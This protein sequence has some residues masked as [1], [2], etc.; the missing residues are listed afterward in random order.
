M[1][2]VISAEVRQLERKIAA[3]LKE[4]DAE[5]AELL[6]VAQALGA[7][8][9]SAVAEAAPTRRRRSSPSRGSSTKRASTK[10]S[11]SSATKRSSRSASRSSSARKSSARPR[12]G[13]REQFLAAVQAQPGVT[14]A[15]VAKKL[16]LDDATSM[17]RHTRELV[18]KGLIRKDGS[19]L[20]PAKKK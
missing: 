12:V 16:G 19:K 3:R 13:R 2:S 8:V 9:T 17:Y 15:E 1:S 18:A 5:R 14:T 6:R 11:T 10:R 4:L 7:Q 20:H